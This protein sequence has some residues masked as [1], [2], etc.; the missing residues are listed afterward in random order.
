MLHHF[1]N[2]CIMWQRW[3]H[4]AIKENIL[5]SNWSCSNRLLF[6]RV[7]NF[8]LKVFFFFKENLFVQK[9]L[10]TI[11]PEL[12]T[13][14]GSYQWEDCLFNKWEFQECSFEILRGDVLAFVQTEGKLKHRGLKKTEYGSIWKWYLPICEKFIYTLS[15]WKSASY[16]KVPP[17]KW[18]L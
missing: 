5:L 10:V 13:F 18:W 17:K 7:W 16:W 9:A 4:W 2:N 1:K 12:T 11:Y 6:I 8:P 15:Y 14:L 3:R